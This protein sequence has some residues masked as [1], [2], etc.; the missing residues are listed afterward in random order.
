M[1][2]YW[3]VEISNVVG[4]VILQILVA[5][6]NTSKP[7]NVLALLSR[8]HQLARILKH[9]LDQSFCHGSRVV[10]T[11]AHIDLDEPRVKILIDHEIVANQFHRPLLPNDVPL[12]ALDAP[13]HDVLD[14]LLDR[15]PFLLPEPTRKLSHVPH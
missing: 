12:A 9:H 11:R 3:Y 8:T 5:F 13:N 10:H 1:H 15:P 7:S 4:V 6:I 14:L 2:S